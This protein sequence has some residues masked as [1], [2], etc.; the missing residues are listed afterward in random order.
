MRVLILI[1]SI[2]GILASA[3]AAKAGLILA[4][5]DVSASVDPGTPT[6]E[7][8]QTTEHQL[9]LDKGKRRDVQRWLK[10]LGFHTKL[11]G[12]FDAATRAA[13]TQWQDERGYAATGF[14]DTVQHDALLAE[15][16][17]AAQASTGDDTDHSTRTHRY[18]SGSRGPGGLIGGVMGGLFGRR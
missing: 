14:L 6:E 17:S 13:I 11:S 3:N 16:V 12:H 4:N 5:R 9:G 7:A 8:D 1:L 10:S 18:R 2:V 15:S